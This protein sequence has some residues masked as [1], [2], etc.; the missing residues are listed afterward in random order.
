[1]RYPV[2]GRDISNY[3]LT[4][5]TVMSHAGVEGFGHEEQVLGVPFSLL[6]MGSNDSSFLLPPLKLQCQGQLE[7]GISFPMSRA[8]SGRVSAAYT[9]LT[10]FCETLFVELK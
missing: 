3:E 9:Q 1:M 6:V 2:H 5:V 7:S 10:V 8:E 4:L